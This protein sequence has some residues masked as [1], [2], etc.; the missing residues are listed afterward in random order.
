MIHLLIADTYK[1]QD[2]ILHACVNAGF[3]AYVDA[4]TKEQS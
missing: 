1:D 3:N 2:L 4:T